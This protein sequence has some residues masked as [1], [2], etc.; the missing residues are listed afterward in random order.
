[1]ATQQPV[2]RPQPPVAP[3]PGYR[4]GANINPSSPGSKPPPPPAAPPA[5]KK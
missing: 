2:P 3:R 1:M 4:D 5:P